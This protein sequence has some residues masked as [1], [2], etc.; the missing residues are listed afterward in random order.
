MYKFI[1][2]QP[3]LLPNASRTFKPYKQP[4]IWPLWTAIL[5][6]LFSSM[7]NAKEK[8]GIDLQAVMKQMRFEY[9]QAMKT[10]SV[11]IFNQHILAFK[12]QLS[13]AKKFP[14]TV[15]RLQKATEGLNKVSAVVDALPLP[16]SLDTLQEVKESLYVID[17]LR[18][19]YHDKKPSLWQRFFEMFFGL[20]EGNEALVLLDN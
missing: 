13:I 4:T 19:E 18:D 7:L 3:P 15:E 8:D 17:D 6:I 11:E 2:T 12:T 20:E 10:D 5:M 14:H 16:A 1:S 9:T